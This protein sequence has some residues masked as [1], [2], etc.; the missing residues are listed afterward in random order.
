MGRALAVLI[1]ILT[2][3]SVGLFFS[4]WWFPTT[5]TEHGPRIDQQFM[6]TIV[7]VGIAFV[8]A[9]VGLGWMIWKYGASAQKKEARALYTH[10]SNRLE[11]IWTVVTAVIFIGLAVM[12]QR[13]WAQLHFSS[14]PA[15]SFQVTVVA[16]Q[17]AWNFQYPGADGKFGRTDPK[18]IREDEEKFIGLDEKDPSSKDDITSKTLVIPVNRPVE[19]ILRSKDVTHSFWV[20]QLRFKQDLVPGMEIHVHFT[21]TKVGQFQLACAELCGMNHFSMKGTLLVLT[22]DQHRELMS[23]APTDFNSKVASFA[24]MYEVGTIYDEHGT[25]IGKSY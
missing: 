12:G 22:E 2:L 24:A 18:L 1:W 11:V 23:V 7:V 3:A 15:G 5:I 6:I 19:L 10:G 13:V 9:Q 17:F 8:A 16:Q 14:A 21:P 20:P 4:G 25:K